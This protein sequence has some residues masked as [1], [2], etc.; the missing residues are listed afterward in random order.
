MKLCTE[1]FSSL[2]TKSD[3]LGETFWAKET[4]ESRVLDRFVIFYL[5][6]SILLLVQS[7]VTQQGT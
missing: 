7:I 4:I 3:C 1:F 5:I 2:G 6:L